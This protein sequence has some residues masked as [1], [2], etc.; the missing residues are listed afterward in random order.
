MCEGVKEKNLG[1]ELGR[2]DGEEL[3]RG[4]GEELGRGTLGEEMVKNLGGWFIIIVYILANN[5]TRQSPA[6]LRPPKHAARV[7]RMKIG[8]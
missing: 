8:S 2:G 7:L 4:V 5:A 1:E 3:G 6:R